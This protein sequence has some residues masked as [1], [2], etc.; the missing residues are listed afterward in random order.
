MFEK[1]YKKHLIYSFLV[2]FTSLLI[3]AIYTWNI[4]LSLKKLQIIFIFLILTFVL[5]ISA[6]YIIYLILKIT[7][8]SYQKEIIEKIK[9]EEYK[10]IMDKLEEK[11]KK[12]ES[13]EQKDYI[14]LFNELVPNKN[15][16]KIEEF[17]EAIIKNISQNLSLGQALVYKKNNDVFNVI[18]KY[19]FTG[20]KEPSP[21][22]EGE[23]LPGEAARSKE[24]IFIRDIPDNYFKIESGLGSSLPREIIIIPVYDIN[25]K[26]F[27]IF[28][29]AF[30]N[31]LTEKEEKAIMELHNYL[32]EQSKSYYE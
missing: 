15:Y 25:E 20:E 4:I 16:N 7:D 27:V 23:T 24:V 31:L 26:T 8:E 10:K 2:L 18:Y 5:I 3:I 9:K 11:K 28:E 19:A 21:F 13:Q 6:T 32:C 22:K 12:K 29:L 14:K 17:I 30:L 1:K